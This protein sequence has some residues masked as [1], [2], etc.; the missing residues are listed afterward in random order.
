VPVD[1][2]TDVQEEACR[3]ERPGALFIVSGPSG[4]GKGTLVRALLDRVPGVWLSVS[5]TTRGPRPGEVDG[6]HYV[7]LAA[8][9]FDH[10]VECDGLLEWAE[11]HGNCYG[12]PREPVEAH[13]ADGKLVMLEIDPQGAAQVKRA[14][15]ESVLV[16]IEA[17]SI[18]VLRDRLIKRGS[19]SPEQIERRLRTAKDELAIAGAYDYVIIND[20]VEQATDEL[21][22][23][24]TT[25][26]RRAHPDRR[27]ESL[28]W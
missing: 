23:I 7:F 9:E 8:E 2:L 4:A 14:W 26:A 24:V 28:P 15:P 13:V 17:P 6:V 21:V 12:T 11:I 25:C 5:A 16:F 18:D 27:T 10:L 3:H 1:H 19:E 20:D 22:A